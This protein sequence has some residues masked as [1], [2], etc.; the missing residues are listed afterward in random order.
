MTLRRSM[1]SLYRWLMLAALALSV[2]LQPV[3]ASISELHELTHDSASVHGSVDS[4]APGEENDTAGTL[5]VMHHFAHCCG[6]VVA[7]SMAPLVQ[8]EVSQSEPLNLTDSQFLP[9]RRR[10]APF[11]PPIAA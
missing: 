10:L 4:E 11:R 8:T 3:L 9:I 6:H 2:I 5:H 1:P 7:S